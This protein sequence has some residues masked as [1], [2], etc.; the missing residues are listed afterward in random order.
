MSLNVKIDTLSIES[1][2]RTMDMMLGIM[3]E[4]LTGK[5]AKIPS[6]KFKG[7]FGVLHNIAIHNNRLVGCFN[8]LKKIGGGVIENRPECF[9]PFI[10]DDL[11]IYST[12]E[13]ACLG[14]GEEAEQE[15]TNY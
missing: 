14:E 9:I 15:L 3:G 13:E 8:P 10:I 1:L 12:L 4:K 6:G 11:V 2:S 7:R 5:L